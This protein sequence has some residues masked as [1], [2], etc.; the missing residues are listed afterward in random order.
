M[1]DFVVVVV[2][3]VVDSVVVVVVVVDSVVVDSEVDEVDVDGVVLF[4]S[5]QRYC[6][7][8]FVKTYNTQN[9]KRLVSEIRDKSSPVLSK[10]RNLS[11]KFAGENR[12][13]H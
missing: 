11:L 4:L 3:V 8:I 1:L 7:V 9:I 5:I 6:T 13:D 12:I 2:V 10:E